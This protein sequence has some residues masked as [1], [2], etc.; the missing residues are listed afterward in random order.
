MASSWHVKLYDSMGKDFLFWYT[1]S[2]VLV[3]LSVP[4]LQ[5]GLTEQWELQ[6]GS[7]EHQPPQQQQNTNKRSLSS[8]GLVTQPSSKL[9]LFQCH[10]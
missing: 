10:P 7:S 2:K 9:C 6:L 1:V 5:K 3:Y 4:I 8:T